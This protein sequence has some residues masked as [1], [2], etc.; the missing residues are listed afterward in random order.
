MNASGFGWSR[1][2]VRILPSTATSRSPPPAATIM[3]VRSSSAA[4]P[5]TPAAASASPA[6]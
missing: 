6:V 5:F 3:S 4:S 2:P 1:M